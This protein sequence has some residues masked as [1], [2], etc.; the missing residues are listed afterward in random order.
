[1]DLEARRPAQAGWL[2]VFCLPRPGF[3]LAPPNF[4]PR[5]MVTMGGDSPIA[6]GG[7]PPRA[8]FSTIGRGD[9]GDSE[10]LSGIGVPRAFAKRPREEG[11]GSNLL[12]DDGDGDD[13]ED[14]GAAAPLATAAAESGACISSPVQSSSVRS[15]VMQ[16]GSPRLQGPPTYAAACLKTPSAIT[17]RTSTIP[18]A[19]PSLL[20]PLLKPQ[21]S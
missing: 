5:C 12:D 10:S 14:D 2:S 7:R 8:L 6:S 3:V 20:L 21:L 9:D 19:H 11:G 1:M 13:R 16:T 17:L 18:P 4:P 15:T